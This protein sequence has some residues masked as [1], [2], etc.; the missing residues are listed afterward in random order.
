MDKI[1]ENWQRYLLIEVVARAATR[2]LT[3]IYMLMLRTLIT[4]EAQKGLAYDA[5][6]TEYF[7]K[8]KTEGKIFSL[9]AGAYG[10]IFPDGL[11]TVPTLLNQWLK[12]GLPQPLLNNLRLGLTLTPTSEEGINNPKNKGNVFLLN[13]ASAGPKRI[14]VSLSYNPVLFAENAEQDLG[15]VLSI[16]DG[17]VYHEFVHYLQSH[18]LIKSSGQEKSVSPDAQA[19]IKR[20]QKQ[21]EAG[22]KQDTTAFVQYM[23]QPAEIEGYAR[24]FYLDSR[25]LGIP[26]EQLIDQFFEDMVVSTR[27]TGKWAGIPVT[28]Q[29]INDL[30]NQL[31]TRVKPELIKYAQKNLPCATLLSGKP[32][33]PSCPQPTPTQKVASK[34]VKKMKTIWG[35]VQGLAAMAKKKSPFGK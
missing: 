27:T 21:L 6:F 9:T 1:N 14:S 24:G 28:P 3:R 16:L 32:V 11:D 26:W 30:R 13:G 19:I 2:Q 29:Q 35:G 4:Q 7:K 5:E 25:N 31:D 23:L 20:F 34:A 8:W 33:S 17:A 15:K 12:D 10:Q 18:N 22:L